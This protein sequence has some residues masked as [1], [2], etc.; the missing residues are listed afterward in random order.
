[1]SQIVA[2]ARSGLEAFFEW[3][4]TELAGLLPRGL[5]PNRRRR[6]RLL[7]L[8]CGTDA[9]SLYEGSGANRRL[10]GRDE[11]AD[12]AEALRALVGRTRSRRRQTIVRLPPQRGLRKTLELPAAARD[13]LDQLLKFEMDRLTPFR[14]DEVAF[15]HRVVRSDPQSRRLTIELQLAPK[16]VVDDALDFARHLGLMPVRVELGDVASAEDGA[17]DL[18]PDQ[19][20]RT[21]G[22]SRLNR[23]LALL[24]ILLAAAAVGLPLK[25][26]RSTAADLE[27]EVA[28]AKAEAEA[29][30]ELR[31]RLEQVGVSASFLA[32]EKR[33]IPM[34]SAILAEV[35]RVLPDQAYLT[36]LDWRETTVELE[37]LA[38]GAAALIGR[39]DQS[40]MFGAPQ[41]RSPV[42]PDRR[43]ELER[44][45]V[46]V[47]LT[48]GDG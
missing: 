24:A 46:S 3:W 29:S 19:R 43:S 28:A 34:T 35:T 38:G 47:E 39:L 30:L 36:R 45:H 27:I 17:L 7:V 12:D 5:S 6:R 4:S 40:P 10:I 11:G 9:T 13:D 32:A 2:V 44:F 41:F 1:M 22:M 42:T 23:A 31:E 8:E 18:L 25:Q 15:A 21:S 37:G 33:R 26:R 14:A 48:P 16:A 20:R